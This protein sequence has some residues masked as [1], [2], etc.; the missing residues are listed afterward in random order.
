MP[1]ELQ[2]KKKSCNEAQKSKNKNESRKFK[3]TQIVKTTWFM[4]LTDTNQISQN[5]QNPKYQ[6][7][8]E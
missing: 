2:W 5:E 6:E 7:I 3:P 8:N 4:Q 1:Q